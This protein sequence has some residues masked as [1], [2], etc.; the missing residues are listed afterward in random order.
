[1]AEFNE[2]AMH[3][4][5]QK[6]IIEFRANGGKVLSGPFVNAP[7]LLLTTTGAKSG[8]PFTTPLVYTKD[9]NRIVIIAS[10]GGAPKHP[11]WFHNLKA[12]PTPTIELG[13]ERFQAKAVITSGSERERLFNAQATAMPAFAGYQ[14]NTTRQIPVVVLE[15]V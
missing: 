4:F 15:R 10:K 3:E 12:H 11:A 8:R 6:L 9:G 5:N 1:M 7:L 14:K 2:K 13:T